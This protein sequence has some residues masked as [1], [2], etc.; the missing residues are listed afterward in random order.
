M[1]ATEALH[2]LVCHTTYCAQLMN[3]PMADILTPVLQALK[4]FSLPTQLTFAATVACLVTRAHCECEA[5]P[6]S[7]GKDPKTRLAICSS[8]Q[9]GSTLG[10]ICSCISRASVV[11]CWAALILCQCV[12]GSAH[13]TASQQMLTQT[14]RRDTEMRGVICH[15]MYC[16]CA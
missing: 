16:V 12:R 11:N 14:Q 9:H 2:A 3:L 5:L 8:I 7:A 1:Q 6:K 15:Q 13:C 4:P 10:V